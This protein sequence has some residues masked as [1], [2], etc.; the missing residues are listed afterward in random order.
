MEYCRAEAR[1]KKQQLPVRLSSLGTVGTPQH[2]SIVSGGFQGVSLSGFSSYRDTLVSLGQLRDSFFFSSGRN[3][4][5][6]ALEEGI[7][8]RREKHFPNLVKR[9]ETGIFQQFSVGINLCQALPFFLRR[10]SNH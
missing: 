8:F 7:A 5:I 10:I 3:A 4:N 9:Q 2:D 1:Q 6:A